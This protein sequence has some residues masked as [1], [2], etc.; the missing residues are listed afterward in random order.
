[1]F[2][3]SNLQCGNE[4]VDMHMIITYILICNNESPLLF[5]H[6]GI[7]VPP[8]SMNGKIGETVIF[9]CVGTGFLLNWNVDGKHHNDPDIKNRAISESSTSLSG[10]KYSNLTVL[11]TVEN[12][13]TTL[14]CCINAGST[15]SNNVT[16]T[17]YSGKYSNYRLYTW[18]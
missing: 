13:G 8:E 7:T 9:H 12:N 2:S 3:I 18:D 14:Q 4:P 10:V 17:V 6:A 15:C 11:A 1:M 5:L 16:L